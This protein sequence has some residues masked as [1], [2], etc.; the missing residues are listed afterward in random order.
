MHE[1]SM[2]QNKKSALRSLSRFLL[3]LDW[4]FSN[5][6]GCPNL[7]YTLQIFNKSACKDL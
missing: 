5:Q 6:G 7:I 2:K 4:I 1:K 3:H